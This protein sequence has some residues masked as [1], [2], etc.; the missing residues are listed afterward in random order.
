VKISIHEA[1]ENLTKYIEMSQRGVVITI[2]INNVP[3]CK[4]VG[5]HQATTK[6]FGLLRGKATIPDDFD[7]HNQGILDMFNGNEDR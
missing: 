4:M 2:N 3:A 6:R 5:V 7:H 1:K